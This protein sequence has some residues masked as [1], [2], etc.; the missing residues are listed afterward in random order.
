MFL[1]AVE[2]LKHLEDAI[3]LIWINTDTLIVN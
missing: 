3:L 1:P 2:T